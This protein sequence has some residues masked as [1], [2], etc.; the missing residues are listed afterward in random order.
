MTMERRAR[1]ESVQMSRRQWMVCGV[2]A[3]LGEMAPLNVSI[4]ADKLSKAAVFY[5]DHSSPRKSCSFCA[6]YLPA[7]EPGKAA[8][9]QVV[10]GDIAPQGHCVIW[11]ERNPGDRCA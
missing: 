10:A 8:Q 1:K 5:Q 11:T 7:T 4:A 3:I 9:C 6:H 2:G